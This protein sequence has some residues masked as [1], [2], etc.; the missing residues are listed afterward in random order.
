MIEIELFDHLTECKRKTV[1][2]QMSVYLSFNW[3]HF[4]MRF[5]NLR[6]NFYLLRT[7][8]AADR[9]VESLRFQV[10]IVRR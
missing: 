4:E 6:I 7:R 5:L 3:N 2:K 8:G 9:G 10:S 1:F